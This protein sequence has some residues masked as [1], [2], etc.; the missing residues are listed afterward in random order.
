MIRGSIPVMNKRFSLLQNSQAGSGPTQPTDSWLPADFSPVVVTRAVKLASR[1]RLLAEVS[2]WILQGI[3][4]STLSWSRTT[5]I[6]FQYNVM[7]NYLLQTCSA[8]V[9]TKLTRLTRWS[10]GRHGSVG[11][12]T[13]CRL[14]RPEIECRSQG[15]SKGLRPIACWAC[16]FESRRWHEH[17]CCVLLRNDTIQNAGLSRQRNKYG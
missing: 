11:I 13:C 9:V 7:L 10:V 2:E 6:V 12:A 16:G 14:D 15:P 3:Y 8:T 5:D 17:L 4:R 1:L